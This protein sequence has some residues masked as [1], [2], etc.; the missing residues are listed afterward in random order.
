VVQLYI[1]QLAG[2]AGPRPVREL[3]GFEKMRL[4]PGQA[5]TAE[6]KITDR[7]LGY[8]DSGGRWVTDSGKFMLWI[9]K[10]SASGEPVEFERSQR[11]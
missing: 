7:E 4:E 8:Y 3:R 1:R 2:S 11:R 10:D 9:A 6:F 5:Q